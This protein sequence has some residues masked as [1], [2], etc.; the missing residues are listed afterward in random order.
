MKLP[1]LMYHKITSTCQQDNLSVSLQHLEKQF[2]YLKKYHFTTITFKEL[3]EHVCNN[4]PLPHRPIM[5]T[6]DDGYKDNFELMYPLLKKY[7]LK[8][9][10]FLV[11]QFIDEC[12]NGSQR[13]YL[14]LDE[15]NQMDGGMVEFGFHSFSHK[16]YSDL[17]LNEI[18]QDLFNM[19]IKF[20]QL[21]IN[22]QPCF[23]YPYG[24]F[25][26]KAKPMQKWLEHV[27]KKHGIQLAFRIGNRI[28]PLPLKNRLLIERIDVRGR[29]QLWKFRLMCRLGRKWL[30][31]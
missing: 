31:F 25:F 15:I 16:S 24:A 29:D 26:R 20:E 12:S 17:S 19:R 18:D 7:F 14:N 22:I 21:N 9:N 10:I 13:Q 4:H 3:I 1:I 27:L 2:Q 30:P 11:A 5:L 28:N 23:A 8:A 6:F